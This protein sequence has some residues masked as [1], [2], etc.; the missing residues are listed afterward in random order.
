MH[1]HSN[2]HRKRNANRRLR[3]AY[4]NLT[5]IIYTNED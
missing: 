4:R 2:R 3:H 1:P 5:R